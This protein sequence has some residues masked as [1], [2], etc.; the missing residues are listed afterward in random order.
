M[1]RPA[2]REP[3]DS[4]ALV[5]NYGDRS[6][7]EVFFE[8]G[9][10]SEEDH[11]LLVGPVS[12]A[13][14]EQNDRRHG[15]VTSGEKAAE[16]GISRDQHPDL[17]DRPGEDLVVVGPGQAV[18]GHVDGVVTGCVEALGQVD[19]EALVNEEPQAGSSRGTRRS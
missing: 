14:P 7:V 8:S 11:R 4:D 16:V 2:D 6:G 3:T 5:V 1:S 19:R 17:G 10:V 18:G 12:G 13:S 15:G 9:Q